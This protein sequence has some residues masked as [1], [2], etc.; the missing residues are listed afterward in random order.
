M[1]E[2]S[3]TEKQSTGVTDVTIPLSRKV[4]YATGALADNLIMTGYNAM[5]M[6]VFNVFMHISPIILGWAISIPRFF[7]AITDPMM[8]NFS[9]NFRSRWGRRKPFVLAGLVACALI[10]PILWLVPARDETTVLVWLIIF[11]TLYFLAY[12]VFIIPYQAMGFEMTTDVDERMNLLQWPN[13]I[14]LTASLFVPWLP[15]MIDWDGFGNQLNGAISVSILT[16]AILLICC[17]FTLRSGREITSSQDQERISLVKAIK[18]T[19]KNR[20]YLLVVL[21]NLTVLVGLVTMGTFGYYINVFYLF[22]G[23]TDKG[24]E[25]LGWSGSFYAVVSMFSVFMAVL[26]S[27]R[28]GKKPAV[29]GLLTVTALGAASLWWTLT[30]ENPWLQLVSTFVIGLGLQGS[31][32]IF[33]IMI[34]D[35]IEEDE[36]VTGLRREGIYSAVGGFSRKIAVSLGALFGGYA[37]AWSGFDAAVAEKVGLSLEVKENMKLIMVWGQVAVVL[38]GLGLISFYPITRARALETQEKLK[39]IRAMKREEA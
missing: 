13:Y 30:P 28:F 6:P 36:L 39:V 27:N 14:G 10:L 31:W 4:G 17:I 16:G 32:M 34:G 35:V 21:S 11:G 2:S 19:A 38:L 7:D 8:G 29:Q 26:I 37:L 3:T 24:T 20:P 18:E 9:D 5:I 12:T 15:R 33:Y 25:M 22:D 23:D 1:Q